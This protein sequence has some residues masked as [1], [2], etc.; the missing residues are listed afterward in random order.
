MDMIEVVIL[1]LYQMKKVI[2]V[3][4]YG[5][6]VGLGLSL[7]FCVDIVFVEKNVVFVMNFI[8]IGFVLDGGGYYLLKKRIG[9]V[10][11]KKLIWSGKKFF[12]VE[13]VDMGFFD[14][15]FVGGFVEGV[16]FFIEIF[17]VLFFLVMIEMK[18][19]FQS[20]QFEELKKVFF[21]ECSV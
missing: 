18:V 1:M 9:E 16:R 20:F 19:I 7:V 15:I 2:I 17:L 14:G 4:I 5:V 12:V 13:V 10:K 8:G 21:F 6:V 3:V 11:V